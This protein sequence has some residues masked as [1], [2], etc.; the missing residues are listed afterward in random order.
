LAAGAI[1]RLEEGP[2][3][4]LQR[5]GM[6]PAIPDKQ[7]VEAIKARRIEIVRGVES[8][9]RLADGAGWSRTYHAC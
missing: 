8:G 2:F 5:V 6:A 9:A 3:A 1:P 4:R 7:V